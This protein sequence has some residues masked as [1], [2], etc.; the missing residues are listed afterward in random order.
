MKEKNKKEKAR[1]YNKGRWEHKFKIGEKVCKR[2]YVQSSKNKTFKAKLGP[3][4]IGPF[5]VAEKLSM[6]A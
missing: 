6:G 5:T 1:Y 3:K 2:N 4:F